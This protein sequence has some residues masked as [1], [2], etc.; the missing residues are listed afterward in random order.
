M[1]FFEFVEE[2]DSK[3][4][5]VECVSRLNLQVSAMSGGTFIDTL[6]NS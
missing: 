2:E 5:F 4:I 3:F 6:A 1:L